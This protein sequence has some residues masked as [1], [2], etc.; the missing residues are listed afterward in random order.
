[1]R[2]YIPLGSISEVALRYE[3]GEI[4]N[5]PIIYL[6]PVF[7]LFFIGKKLIYFG[8]CAFYTPTM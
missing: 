5:S 1:M 4:Q 8:S 7:I 3:P 6:T 2:E